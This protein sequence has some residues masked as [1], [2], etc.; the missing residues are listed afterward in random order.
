MS[1]PAYRG[2]QF[3]RLNSGRVWHFDAPNPNDILLADIAHSLSKQDRYSG[4]A[5]ILISVAQHSVEVAKLV[6]ERTKDKELAA[7]GLLH[8]ACEAYVGDIAYPLK[9]HPVMSGWR[10][11]EEDYW[12]MIAKRFGLPSELPQVVHEADMD[13]CQAEIQWLW[14]EESTEW[15]WLRPV[16][17][18]DL[19]PMW[20]QQSK[21]SKDSFLYWAHNLGIEEQEVECGQIQSG[22]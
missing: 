9:N 4:H 15:P 1:E 14:G 17:P 5:P 13:V 11:L 20:P 21:T 7:C 3:I 12:R 18:R 22:R 6:L 19:P 16:P 10:E 8:D 2:K